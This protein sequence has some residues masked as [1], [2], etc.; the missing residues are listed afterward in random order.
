MNRHRLSC[1]ILGA[2]LLSG[3]GFRN[4]YID[5]HIKRQVSPWHLNFDDNGHA[6]VG[7]ERLF[8]NEVREYR[9]FGVTILDLR[10]LPKDWLG[11]H[12]N[13]R[14]VVS[15]LEKASP[16][17]VAGLRP[18]DRILKING[19][20]ALLSRLKKAFKD[21]QRIELEAQRPS[22][23]VIS[24]ITA[25][26]NLGNEGR[27]QVFDFDIRH[28]NAGTQH[29]FGPF[30]ILWH[31]RK[32]VLIEE[33]DTELEM[34]LA[35]KLS[36]LH[37]QRRQ[38]KA[39]PVLSALR[40]KIIEKENKVDIHYYHREDLGFLLNLFLYQEQVNVSTQESKSRVRLFWFFSFG[41]TINDELDD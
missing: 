6:F 28:G 37:K 27:V 26:S 5:G 2:L 22:G 3:C 25:R 38:G 7:R 24:V 41:D 39:S 16:L 1:L 20:K 12:S 33:P 10:E 36:D 8:L 21:P 14:F 9:Y 34:E 4:V 30:S 31:W 17:A 29:S 18:Y 11:G 23:R 35:A 32:T 40:Q 15:H 19:K 13:A